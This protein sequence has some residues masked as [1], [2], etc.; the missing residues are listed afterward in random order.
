MR[1]AIVYDYLAARGGM[2]RTVLTLAKA[3]DA[4]VWTTAFIPEKTY[5]E[6]KRVRVISHEPMLY[7]LSG[8]YSTNALTL[9]EIALRFRR[10][11]LSDYDLII[12]SGSWGKHVGVR[13]TNH[14][15]LHYENT[16]PRLF[17]DL[18]HFIKDSLPPVERPAFQA[19]SFFMKRLDMQA[20]S[21]IDK[22]VCNSENVR[23]RIK[24]FYGREATVVG[25]PVRIDK[26]RRSSQSGDYFLS[27]QR[28]EEA[29]RIGMQLEIFRKL[30]EERL[31]I[32]GS[33][34]RGKES[35]FERLKQMAPKNVEF[36]GSVS[37]EELSKLYSKCKA[38]IQT[39]MD[40][41]FGEVPVEAMASGK[42]CIAV[43]EGGFRE[44]IVHGKTGILVDPPYEENFVKIIQNFDKYR[45]DPKACVERAQE[46]S[47]AKFVERFKRA[48]D[49][50]LRGWQ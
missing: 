26:F 9:T 12:T 45:F 36:V 6:L 4:D 48:V 1:V 11:N 16:P 44:T 10:M 46:F 35:Y 8:I 40:E 32:V 17:Y 43:N 3:F 25:V 14:P 47:E 5:P 2:E 13:K 33:P 18:Y 31:I 39:S 41:D 28:I 29:K 24:K 42:P 27:V 37:D 19:W 34:S 23:K 15:Q 49:E 22:I 7:P 38:V 21:Y 30:P 20:T 50:L